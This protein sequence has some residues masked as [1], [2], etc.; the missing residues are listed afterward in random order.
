MTSWGLLKTAG[1]NSHI[2]A[3]Q[4]YL[5][6]FRSINMHAVIGRS[7]ICGGG[8]SRCGRAG[9]TAAFRTVF[10]VGVR[11]IQLDI[12]SRGF[13]PH[14]EILCKR[15]IAVRLRYD[16]MNTVFQ[17]DR[18][19]GIHLTSIDI[20]FCIGRIQGPYRTVPLPLPDHRYPV[21]FPRCG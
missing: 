3:V 6:I 17:R 14:P 2:V 11:L 9:R 15:L 19:R 5:H 4:I 13:L 10:T 20:Q 7:R 16:L 8:R 21:L 12:H 1:G 18:L